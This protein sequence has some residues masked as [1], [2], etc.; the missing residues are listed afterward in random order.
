MKIVTFLNE[1]KS[2]LSKII[3]PRRDEVIGA[4]IIVCLLAAFAAI[5]LGCMDFGFGQLIKKL[6]G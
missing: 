4:S 3:W 1:V 6:I 5:L 2:E